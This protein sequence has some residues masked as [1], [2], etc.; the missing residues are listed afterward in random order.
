[1]SDAE[2]TALV[3]Q[4]RADDGKASFASALPAPI[5]QAISPEGLRRLWPLLAGLGA[6]AAILLAASVFR[7]P[8]RTVVF[9]GLP[10][11]E[12]AAVMDSLTAAGFDARLDPVTGAPTVP[13]SALHSARMTLAGAG[14]PESG[15]TGYDLLSEMPFGTS[16]AVESARLRQTQETELA[17]SVEAMRG[18]KAAR[19]HI[20]IPEPSAF[21]RASASPTASVFLELA[22]GRVL[23]EG[24]ALAITHLISSSVPGLAAER[25]SIVDQRG[26]LLS[27]G[28]S[29]RAGEREL[30]YRAA[31]EQQWRDRIAAILT[32][33]YGRDG[34]TAEV[35]LDVDFTATESTSEVYGKAAAL[36][37]EQRSARPAT[38]GGNGAARGIP[39]TLT[40]QPPPAAQLTA[41][42]NE[43]EAGE[44]EAADGSEA[45]GLD[46]SY[47][48]NY[49]LDREVAVTTAPTGRLKRASVAVVLREGEQGI[50][51]RELA[52][53]S[54]LLTGALGISEDRGDT[55]VVK[56]HAFDDAAA[57]TEPLPFYRQPWVHEWASLGVVLI[58]GLAALLLIAKPL[59]RLVSDTRKEKS[60]A[61]EGAT[62]E[63]EAEITA[64]ET[65]SP[66]SLPAPAYLARIEGLRTLVDADREQAFDALS[67]LLT[68][69]SPQAGD[70]NA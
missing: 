43:N 26:K 22:D 37:S 62:S 70:A 6:I 54:V 15:A 12:K 48:R 29:D 8:D 47:T 23:G 46:E 52:T 30:E 9:A 55:L 69:E 44:P 64:D 34:Y 66:S 33:L 5:Q 27:G 35:A 36:R 60:A 53:A 7:T 4:R 17:R 20:A 38:A 61:D 68:A 49:E 50:L 21:V 25:V 56:A 28:V 2:T 32:P 51:E 40:N 18:V 14:L 42:Q 59:L 63:T 10:D 58:L 16:R 57:A 24:Q 41:A 67:S 13:R 19:V 39:G 31:L 11:A 65:A 1:M 3:P 45:N